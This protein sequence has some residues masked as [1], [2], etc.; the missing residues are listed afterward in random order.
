MA[1]GAS[2]V[3]FR[4][5][6]RKT[7]AWKIVEYLS[8]PEVQLRFYALTGDLPPTR[9]A[10]ADT[11]LANNRYARAFRDQLERMVPLPKVPEWEQIATKVFEYGEQA[12]R[13]RMSVDST[14]AAL[15][16]DVNG[17][18]EKRRWM[19]ERAEKTRAAAK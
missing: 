13:G 7:D 2:L 16:R 5:S 9:T 17:L 4:G 10:W 19:A 15:D 1:G 3:V 6:R 18:L 12:I 8:R 11:A 14:L